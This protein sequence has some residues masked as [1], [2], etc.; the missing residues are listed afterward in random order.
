MPD[1]EKTKMI[2]GDAWH[3]IMFV[4][5][6]ILLLGI[7]TWMGFVRCNQIPG[8]CQVYDP[9]YLSL[10]GKREV[11]IV[12]GDDGIGNPQE[13]QKRLRDPRIVGV[14]ADTTHIS[15]V[16]AGNLQ[17][18]DLVIVERARTMSTQQLQYFIDFVDAGGK[19]VWTGDAGTKMAAGDEQL[20]EDDL[21]VNA[22][23]TALSPWA[24]RLGKNTV[25]FDT[26]ISV[27]YLGNF[28]EMNT[29]G[30]KPTPIGNLLTESTGNHQ[31]IYGLAANQL[32]YVGA[33]DQLPLDFAVV[34][35][36]ESIGSKR[37]LTL[38]YG[39]VL[40]SKEGADFG[41]YFPMIVTSGVGEKAAYY[42]QPPEMFLGTGFNYETNQTTLGQTNLFIANLYKFFR[43]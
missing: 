16:G 30:N 43:K 27:A 7:V 22:K 14:I 42:A 1:Y 28:C 35:E 33:N 9:L 32:L 34:K 8:W 40:K 18:Y 31:L 39:T 29:C 25:R 41:R 11:L 15:R 17:N 10:T 5:L 3:V 24:R 13:L 6:V 21:D 12:Y 2:M 36:P 20:F 38:D 37:I 4:V 23:H 19:L 26:V